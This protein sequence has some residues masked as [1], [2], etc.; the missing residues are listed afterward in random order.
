M[1]FRL[2]A[3]NERTTGEIEYKV[4]CD[5]DGGIYWVRLSKSPTN[6]IEKVIPMSTKSVSVDIW[7]ALVKYF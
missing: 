2:L 7:K 5:I 6:H 4:R 3:H 1:M